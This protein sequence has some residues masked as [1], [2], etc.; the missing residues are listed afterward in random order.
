M[1]VGWLAAECC[2][3]SALGGPKGASQYSSRPG[4]LL[5]C[6]CVM[7]ACMG[8]QSPN[9]AEIL[10]V[11]IFH[12]TDLTAPMGVVPSA[13]SH[14]HPR[15]MPLMSILALVLLFYVFAHALT[16]RVLVPSLVLWS[17]AQSF[18]LKFERWRSRRENLG[19]CSRRKS[20]QFEVSH[21]Y[22]Y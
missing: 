22:Y 4:W 5:L 7:A 6:M 11:L 17:L 13:P 20:K 21:Y 14:T 16:L 3:W 8:A 15:V 18:F 1:A 19:R 9:Q 12:G 2:M 10:I